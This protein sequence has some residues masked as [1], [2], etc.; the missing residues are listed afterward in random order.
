M[1]LDFSE[2]QKGLKQ[3]LA[4]LLRAREVARVVASIARRFR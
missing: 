1:N 4:R 2:E 3:E